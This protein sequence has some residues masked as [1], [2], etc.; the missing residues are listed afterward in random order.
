MMDSLFRYLNLDGRWADF[1]L[2]GVEQQPDGSL[3]LARVPVVDAAQDLTGVPEPSAPTGLAVDSSGVV[4]F[5]VPGDPHLYVYDP[6][7]G[8]TG[9][10]PCLRGLRDPRGLALH[11]QRNALLV[12]DTAAGEVKIFDVMDW[13]PLET[14]VT[15]ESPTRIAVDDSGNSYVIDSATK[16]LHRFTPAGDPDPTFDPTLSDPTAVATFGSQVY[17]L[18]SDVSVFSGDGDS[19]ASGIGK[20]RLVKPVALAVTADSIY[21]GDNSLRRILRFVNGGGFEFAGEAIGFDGPVSALA[22]GPDGSI[23]VSTGQA[24]TPLKLTPAAGYRDAGIAWGGPFSGGPRKVVWHSVDAEADIPVA[25]SL[26]LYVSTAD[27]LPAVDPEA[28]EPFAA[29]TPAPEGLLNFYI[30]GD[31]SMTLWVGVALTGNGTASPALREMRARF[32]QKT[33]LPSANGVKLPGVYGDPS[34]AGDFLTRLLALFESCYFDNDQ[35]LARMPELFDPWA[36]PAGYLPW[37]ASWM[38]I[39]FDR[40]WAVSKQREA[41]ARAYQAFARRGTVQGLKDCIAFET[42]LTVAI[43]EPIQNASWWV[44]PADANPCGPQTP[45]DDGPCPAC[46]LGINTRLAQS[47]PAGAVVGSTAILDGSRITAPEDY[48]TPLFDELAHRFTVILP[49]N[50]PAGSAG[51]VR[52]VVDREKPAHT[53]YHLCSYAPGMAVGL[54]ARVGIDTI[55]GGASPGLRLD[56][57]RADHAQLAGTAARIGADSRIGEGLRI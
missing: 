43:E 14:R 32:N 50:A 10:V 38:A 18:D 51:A 24:A 6:C 23:L 25:G 46:M 21:V 30:G 42:G 31:P 26:T 9:P 19:I 44:L 48:A 37:L 1:T 45:Q 11:R 15:L 40:K 34:P 16:S 47:E 35:T 49:S 53:V 55:V 33:W 57:S 39:D 54:Q 29:W 8:K 4:Y 12:C 13:T 7:T 20:G 2:H 3:A 36:I 56:E 27:K 41:I 28:T 52:A 22:I 5:T 17:V